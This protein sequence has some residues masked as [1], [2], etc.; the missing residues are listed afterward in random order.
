MEAL[1]CG[2]VIVTLDAP[3]MNEIVTTE[4]GLHAGWVRS[5]P[6]HLATRYG[7]DEAELERAVEKAVTL[8]PEELSRRAVAAR[9]RFDLIDRGFRGAFREVVADLI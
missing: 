1:S 2:A 8:P 7:A 6:M 3:P 4:E 5:W 9:R